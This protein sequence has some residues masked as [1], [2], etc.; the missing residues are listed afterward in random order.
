L[1][2]AIAAVRS[3]NPDNDRIVGRHVF[4][5]S[6]R[7]NVGWQAALVKPRRDPLGHSLG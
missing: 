1:T 4:G 5:V 7:R 3:L 2:A 6:D